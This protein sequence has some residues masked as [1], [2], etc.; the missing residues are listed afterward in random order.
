M[1]ALLHCRERHE[2]FVVLWLGVGI[3]YTVFSFLHVTY[4]NIKMASVLV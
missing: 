2:S 3:N 1:L 4:E